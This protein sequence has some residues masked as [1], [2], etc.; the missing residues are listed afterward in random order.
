MTSKLLTWLF[1]PQRDSLAFEDFDI[2][3]LA[4]EIESKW[5]IKSAGGFFN[6]LNADSTVK[7]LASAIAE[8]AGVPLEEVLQPLV[9]IIGFH[10]SRDPATIRPETFLN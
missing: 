8:T 7:D 10:M 5:G 3:E 9:A 6:S 2:A 4:A 1:G